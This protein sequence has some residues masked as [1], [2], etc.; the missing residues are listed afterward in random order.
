MCNLIFSLC[1]LVVQPCLRHPVFYLLPAFSV[2]SCGRVKGFG[3]WV[4]PTHRLKRE[5]YQTNIYCL[6]YYSSVYSWYCTWNF[7]K[8]P[9]SIDSPVL[10]PSNYN[11]CPLFLTSH[12]ITVLDFS[13]VST[14]ASSVHLLPLMDVLTSLSG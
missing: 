6:R 12:T 13:P 7:S 1:I 4:G 3:L 8:F 11:M 5:Y 2:S 10:S 14:M 9:A